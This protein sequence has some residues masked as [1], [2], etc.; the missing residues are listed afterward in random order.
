MIN[1]FDLQYV[2]R[3]VRY[4]SPLEYSSSN[5]TTSTL[6][7]IDS[8]TCTDSSCGSDCIEYGELSICVN[9]MGAVLELCKNS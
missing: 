5:Q 8:K 4:T 3:V 9:A 7:S 2:L 6:Y 1:T